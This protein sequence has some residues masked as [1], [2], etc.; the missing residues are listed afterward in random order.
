M[1]NSQIK[2]FMKGEVNPLFR[3]AE[4]ISCEFSD[5]LRKEYDKY[6]SEINKDL[7]GFVDDLRDGQIKVPEK[8]QRFAD[9]YLEAASLMSRIDQFSCEFP[10]IM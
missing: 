5:L 9:I 10:E 2:E 7:F 4:Y 8:L 1:D 6:S 3:L